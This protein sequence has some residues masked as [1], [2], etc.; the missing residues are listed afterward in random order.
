MGKERLI[1]SGAGAH[2][3]RRGGSVEWRT[4]LERS[5]RSQ[6]ACVVSVCMEVAVRAIEVPVG[7]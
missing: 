2:R 1:T 5:P 4:D 3:K 6:R 7:R